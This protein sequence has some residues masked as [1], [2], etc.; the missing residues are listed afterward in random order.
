MRLCGAYVRNEINA[1]IDI[2]HQKCYLYQKVVSPSNGELTGGGT[3][4]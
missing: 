4:K 1:G 3:W 2:K